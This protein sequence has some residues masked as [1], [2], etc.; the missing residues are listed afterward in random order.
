MIGVIILT[1]ALILY[2]KDKYRYISYFIYLSFMLGYNGGFGLWTDDIIEFK[3]KD[4]AIIYTFIISLYLIATNEYILPKSRFITWYKIFLAF[5]VCDIIFS[6]VHYDFTSYQIL[7]GGRDFL[8][9]FSLPI[10]IKIKPKELEKLFPMLL[11]VTVITSILYVFQIVLKRPLMPYGGTP[12]IDDSTGII[13]LYNFP[14]LLDFFLILSFADSKLFRNGVIAFR[15]LFFVTLICTQG[16]TSIFTSLLAIA[17][18][19]LFLGNATKLLKVVIIV[20]LLFIPFIDMMSNR[21][22]KGD[23][24]EDLQALREGEFQRNY[25]SDKGGTM[26]YRFAWCYERFNYLMS[27]PRGEQIFGLGLISDSQPIVKRMYHF[28]IGLHDKVTKDT[29]QMVTPDISY[30][31]LISRLGIVGGII[32]LIFLVYMAVFLFKNR[33]LNVLTA[34]CTAQIIMLFIDSFSGSLLSEPMNLAIFFIVI[35][36]IYRNDEYEL[37][38]ESE[39]STISNSNNA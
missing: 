35:G 28:K 8:L 1:I 32:Y 16:R 7:Q 6:Y 24:N 25:S 10:L 19:L 27:R 29:V 20:G 21:I 33:K 39:M 13:R 31:N 22:K 2:F 15:I 38:E 4:L 23:T 3:N 11:W 12:G 30:G 18:T 5:F 37:S 9:M 17:L 14:A 36:C 26:T 34:V